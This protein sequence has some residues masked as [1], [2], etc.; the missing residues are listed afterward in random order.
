MNFALHH[1]DSLEILPTFEAS[2]FDAVVTDPPYG[3]RFMGKAWDGADIV[4]KV[5]E[6]RR[7][8]QNPSGRAGPR[9]E[10]NSAAAAAGKYDRRP[11]ANVAFQRWTKA[12]AKQT[13]RVMKP[14]AYLVAFCSTR[15]YHRMVAGIEDAGFEIRD[16]LAWVFGSGFPKSHNLDGEFEGWGTALKPAWEP[17]VLARKPLD[18]TVA[19]NVRK[20]GT[21]ALNID[22]CRVATG[23][24]M[25]KTKNPNI[26]GGRYKADNSDRERDRDFEQ[27]A[28]GRWPAN[29][30]HDGSE[31]VVSQFPTEA[32]AAAPV[33]QRN[34]DKFRNAY[35]TFNGNH[36]E[37]G[38][39]F[40]ADTGSAARF[41][42]CAKASAAD[43]NL[44]GIENTHP[45]VKPTDLMRWLCRLV[46]PKGGK[47]LDPFTGSGSTGR[48]ALLEGFQFVGIEKDAAYIPVARAR[49]AEAV[50]PL[51]AQP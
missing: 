32:G 34:G 7:Q 19:A 13:Y 48:G 29:L 2:S 24:T 27:H 41:Y 36:D 49:L 44:G 17:I 40:H 47:I 8:R 15:T 43:R 46:T 1:G 11:S 33:R 14:G 51:F 21:G 31:E 37:E 12:W 28:G 4:A 26:R 10:H 23:D 25:S 50:G 6:R 9:G 20:H 16:Q 42:Y 3:I 45:T 30:V 18:G 38:S 39:T 35:G 22:A 5:D